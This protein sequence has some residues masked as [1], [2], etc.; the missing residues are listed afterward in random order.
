M[1]NAPPKHRPV[2]WVSPEEY[3]RTRGSAASRGYDAKWRVVR[4]AHLKR[5][6]ACVWCADRA[7]EVD[8][9]DGNARNNVAANLRSACKP[10]HSRRT[11]RDQGFASR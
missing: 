1:P 4:A 10:C 5:Y 6:P 8:H 2:G 11:A 9:I 7:T 3:D